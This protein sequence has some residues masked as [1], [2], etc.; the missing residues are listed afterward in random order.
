MSDEK[1]SGVTGC[2]LLKSTFM[3][4][5]KN[6][7]HYTIARNYCFELQNLKSIGLA[8][9]GTGKWKLKANETLG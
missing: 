4:N 5:G 7:T 3:H 2:Y 8:T 1:L 6:H 9:T